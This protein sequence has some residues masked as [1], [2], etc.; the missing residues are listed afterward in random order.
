MLAWIDNDHF[1]EEDDD[2]DE[3]HYPSSSSQGTLRASPV[4]SF[5]TDYP[6]RQS[7]LRTPTDLTVHLSQASEFRVPT[8]EAPQKVVAPKYTPPTPHDMN[9]LWEKDHHVESCRNCQRRF[10]FLVRRVR[11][12]LFL[13]PHD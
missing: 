1:E 11:V 6:R 3:F 10:S 2:D 9:A 7:T 5:S 4:R 13:R 8:H 12:R